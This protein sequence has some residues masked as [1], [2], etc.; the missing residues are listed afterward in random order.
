MTTQGED[1]IEDDEVDFHVEFL[2]RWF[3]VP[4]LRPLDE[5]AWAKGVVQESNGGAIPPNYDELAAHFVQVAAMARGGVIPEKDFIQVYQPLPDGPVVAIM[6]IAAIPGEYVAGPLEERARTLALHG[7]GILEREEHRLLDL[8]VGEAARWHG[9]QRHE[10]GRSLFR[11]RRRLF[12][13]ALFLIQPAEVD[14]FRIL[15][16]AWWEELALG[17]GILQH[18]ERMVESI[19]FS[20]IRRPRQR[21]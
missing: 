18:V 3:A 4:C 10:G 8:P 12:E 14:D 7:A 15:V 17:P 11:R 1:F 2:Q 20:P 6:T 5:L 9:I 19:R 16:N 21:P 13:R